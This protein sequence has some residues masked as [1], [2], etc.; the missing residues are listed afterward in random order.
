M[1]APH[2]GEFAVLPPLLPVFLACVP[3]FI[4]LGIY[5]NNR[6]RVPH[7]TRHVRGAILWADLH[8][9]FRLS[10][11]PFVT[12]WMDGIH[13]AALPTALYG[14]VLLMAA[15]AC[16]IC[17]GRSSPGTAGSRCSPKPRAGTS[18]ESRHRCFT[19]LRYLPRLSRP[20]SPG[21]CTCG[22]PRYG[23]CPTAASNAR[24]LHAK[25]RWRSGAPG[26]SC[27]PHSCYDESEGQER[28]TNHG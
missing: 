16:R 20:G 26:W 21:R 8:P 13:F 27:R 28:K 12:G 7:V 9:L 22:W 14:M 4:Y 5:W 23:G 6:H 10:L 11:F 17:G 18:T 25:R 24:W 15:V 2:G 19:S 3:S 1:K